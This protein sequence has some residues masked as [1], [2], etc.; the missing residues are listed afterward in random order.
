MSLDRTS[1]PDPAVYFEGEGVPLK[2]PGKWKTGRCDFHGGS[3]SLRVNTALGAWVCMSCGEKGGD[4]LAFHMQRHGLEFVDACKAIGAWVDE[5]KPASARQAPLPFSAR[6]ALE[7]VRFETLL[8][9]MAA[10][11]LAKGVELASGDRERLVKAAA[12]IQFIAEGIAR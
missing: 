2:G 7:V 6:A 1:L 4:V 8:V 12:R 9:A 10:C 3:D 11:N 5:G